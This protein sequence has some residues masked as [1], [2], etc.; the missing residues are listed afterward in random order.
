MRT[1]QKEKEIKLQVSLSL[2]HEFE[3]KGKKEITFKGQF[4]NEF[5]QASSMVFNHKAPW[6]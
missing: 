6:I 5:D 2:K 1:P 4:E 3:E